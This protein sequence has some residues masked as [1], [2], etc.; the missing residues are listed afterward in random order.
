MRSFLQ[1]LI[2]EEEKKVSGKPLKHL[3]HVEDYVIHHGHEG[4]G[5]A[6][7][8]LRGVHNKL[9]G[10]GGHSLHVSTKWDVRLQ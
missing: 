4:V 8:H 1:Y 9:L 2:K 7:A 10:K 6:D 3:T 5:I